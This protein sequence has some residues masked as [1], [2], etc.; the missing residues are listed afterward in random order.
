M[1]DD[2]QLKL[3]R[4]DQEFVHVTLVLDGAGS[5]KI[6]AGLINNASSMENEMSKSI[7]NL[8]T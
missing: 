1:Q 3:D 5:D 7:L 6:F 2:F 4:F 8:E